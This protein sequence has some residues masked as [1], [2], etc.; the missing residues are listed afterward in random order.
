MK[1]K[2]LCKKIT[3][4]DY[5]DVIALLTNIIAQ[6]ETLLHSLERATAGIGLHVNAHKTEYMSS[7]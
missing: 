6:D 3:D 2:V 7:N 1:Q 4:A 5:A